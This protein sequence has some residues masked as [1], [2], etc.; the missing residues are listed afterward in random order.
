MLMLEDNS[1]E[2]AGSIAGWLEERS[3]APSAR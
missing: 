3:A 2:I 1:R